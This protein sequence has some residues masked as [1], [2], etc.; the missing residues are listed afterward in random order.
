MTAVESVKNTALP[1]LQV[2]QA[3]LNGL[4]FG[5]RRVQGQSGS[6][7][8]TVVKL[9]SADEFSSPATVEIKSSFPI[10]EI[11][12]RWSGTV[13]I[14]GYARSFNAKA[15]PETGEIKQVRTAQNILELVEA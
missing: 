10:G 13:S 7:W 8:L 9:P 5:R 11:N 2:G 12:D 4:V 1:K 6:Y 15:D 14:A 3:F